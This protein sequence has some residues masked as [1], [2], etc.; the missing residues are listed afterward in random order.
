MKKLLLLL[1]FTLTIAAFSMKQFA[2]DDVRPYLH[3]KIDYVKI[4]NETNT[5]SK[6]SI[7]INTLEVEDAIDQFKLQCEYCDIRAISRDY[8]F[9]C[10]ERRY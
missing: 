3:W 4:D 10:R 8:Y 1:I 5:V 7:L 2:Q 6:D 9:I